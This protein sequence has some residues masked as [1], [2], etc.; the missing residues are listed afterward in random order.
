MNVTLHDIDF[1]D[2]IKDIKS[3][4][5]PELARWALNTIA[6]FLLRGRQKEIETHRGGIPAGR[7]QISGVAAARGYRFNPWTGT[8]G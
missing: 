3:G 1:A 4:D 6:C 5:Y 8:E 7:N 2:V